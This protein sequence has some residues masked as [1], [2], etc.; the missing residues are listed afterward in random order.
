[1][2]GA[3]SMKMKRIS[4]LLALLLILSLLGSCTQ[5]TGN[6]SA[7][8]EITGPLIWKATALGGQEMFLFGSIHAAAAELY[9]LPAAIMEAFESCDYLAVEVDMIAF[10]ND[11]AAQMAM[12]SALMYSDERTVAD[13]IGSELHERAKAVMAGL[14]PEIGIPL[15]MLDGFKPF[16]W[17]QMFMAA[18]IERAGLS[19]DHGLDAFFLREAVKRGMEIL[20]VESVEMQLEAMLGFSPPLQAALIEGYL[21]MDEG[22]AGLKELYELWKKGD[23]QAI[24]ALFAADTDDMPKELADEYIDAMLTQRDLGMVAA[25]ERYMSEGKKVFYVVGL[26]HMV[27]D[28]GIVEQLKRKGYK[29]ERLPV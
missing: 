4:L 10:E 23:R 13:E 22:V 5:N 2:K 6:G 17:M 20:E 19:A 16:F 28:N 14:E 12:M 15:E 11:F 27:G 3:T 18:M 26:A 1:M 21:D 24:E 7:G 25:A 9:P 8:D 29:V